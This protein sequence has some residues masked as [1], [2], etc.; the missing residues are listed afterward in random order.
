MEDDRLHLC[1]HLG[2]L[3]PL[4]SDGRRR[5]LRCRASVCE[6]AAATGVDPLLAAALESRNVAQTAEFDGFLDDLPSPLP[7]LATRDVG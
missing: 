1:T 7:L 6:R 5:C 3:G 4:R 2:V